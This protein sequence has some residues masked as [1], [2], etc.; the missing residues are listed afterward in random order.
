[1]LKNNNGAVIARM[2]R[3]SFTGNRRRNSLLILA[4]ALSAC[5]LFTILTVGVTWM[6]MQHRQNIRQLGGDMDA[7][8]YGGFTQAQLET[9]QTSDELETVGVQGFGAWAVRTQYDST[10][11]TEFVWSD[12][13]DWN[14][15]QQPA[16]S[17]VK[18]RYPQ[19]ENEVMATQEALADAGLEGLDVGDTFT[20][21]YMDNNGEHTKEFTI[22]GMWDGYGDKQVFYVSRSFFD[23]S[24]F[25][26]SD[27]GRGFLY[28]KFRSPIVT[29]GMR[30]A[31][32]QRLQLGKKQ[33][34]LVAADTAGSVQILL[35]L[36]GLL[37]ITC[38][39]AY[40]LIYNIMY[41]SV[42]GNVRYYGLLQTIGMTQKQV[43]ALVQKQ[44]RLIGAVGIGIG[45]LAGVGISFGL[46]PAAVRTLGIRDDDIRIAF[47]PA[48]ALLTLCIAALTVWIGSRKPA[49]LATRIT[50][51]QA[52]GYRPQRGRKRTHKTGSGTLLWRMAREQLCRD[53]KKSVMVIAALGVCLSFF[54]CM[55]TLIQS[56]AARTIVSDSMNA[57]L[58]INNDTMQ[59]ETKDKWK[60]LLDDA[61]LNRVAQ[62][63]GVREIHALVNAQIVV[64]WDADFAD[65]WMREFY[66]Y[67]MEEDYDAI[68]A[69]YQQHPEHHA[70]FV[71]GID[72][73][74]F[75]ALNET[76]EQPVSE[77]DF[78]A[79]KVCILFRN[80]LALDKSKTIGASITF[81][82]DEPDARSCTMQI[83]GMTDD[84]YYA[85]L[86]G[87]TPTL[88]VSDSVVRR[89][90]SHPYVGKLRVLYQEEYDEAAEQ[91][92]LQMIADSPYH[93]DFH[94]E[95][96]IQAAQ[97]VERSQGNLMEIGVGIALV[98]AL[99]GM[100]NYLNASVGSIRSRQVELS[101]M[102]SVGMTGR[103]VRQ[104]L[105][106]EGLLYVGASLAVTFTIGL[107][108]TYALFQ[109]MNYLGVPFA[110]PVLPVAAAIAGIALLCAVIP[111][112]AYRSIEKS[113][114]LVERIRGF[115]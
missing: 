62:T 84:S 17:W 73:T 40:L 75:A 19:R 81:H 2:A 60:P 96:K 25:A 9:C 8:L 103:Q 111:L 13:T 85:N 33:R 94:Y 35:G 79:G 98:L 102:E 72:D 76:L 52:L 10:L 42:S 21:T 108:V 59:M 69:D 92:I 68:K 88:I 20:M 112:A 45:V 24:G 95:S 89:I 49:K 11:H 67:W 12:D 7:V 115:E 56:Q 105:I 83:G 100:M 14:T 78:R 107:G 109:S 80:H 57:D 47:H 61:F 74:E 37:L 71:V 91:A 29:Q 4:I 32:E 44:M 6:Q 23:Q 22:S 55:I 18:G 101:V 77:A 51:M 15:I 63:D 64:P 46:I 54:L 66:D 43:Y 38:L 114:S 48:I 82:A 30:D 50:P 106:R 41:L 5:M 27:H 1:M 99:I 39:S 26:L 34:F 110:I 87:G 53:K 3:R 65:Y 90:A 31:V 70:S 113:G 28:L 93:N 16:R 104:L 58:V 36:L 86:L 97:E